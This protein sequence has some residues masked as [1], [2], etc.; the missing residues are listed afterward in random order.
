MFRSLDHHQG[1]VFSL[2]KSQVTYFNVTF[3]KE[4]VAP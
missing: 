4:N 2:L 1:A 3:S